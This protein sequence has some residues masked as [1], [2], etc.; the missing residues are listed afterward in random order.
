M[1]LRWLWY[2]YISSEINLAP[3]QRSY[4]R[5]R[6]RELA[7]YTWRQSLIYL[8]VLVAVVLAALELHQLLSNAF[9]RLARMPLD[10]ACQLLIAVIGWTSIAWVR[11]SSAAPANYRAMREVRIDICPRC[12]YWLKAL[13]DRIRQCPECG[14]A[15]EA[16][17]DLPPEILARVRSAADRG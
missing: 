16:F 2:D 14:A 1:N 5:S 17:P 11:R 13:S 3:I 8:A 15:R 9:P 12:G 4:I 7:P 6:C 10:I